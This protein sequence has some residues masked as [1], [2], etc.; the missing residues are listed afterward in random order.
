[1]NGDL[2]IFCRGGLR[3]ALDGPGGGAPVDC[4]VGR[5]AVGVG[6]CAA[7]AVHRRARG[8]VPVRG[9]GGDFG[10]LGRVVV[11]WDVADVAGSDRAGRVLVGVGDTARRV[12]A[13]HD[14]FRAGHR[15]F[16]GGRGFSGFRRAFGAAGAPPRR[17]V[18]EQEHAGRGRGAGAGFLFSVKIQ[19]AQRPTRDPVGVVGCADGIAGGF[20]GRGSGRDL[21]VLG[22]FAP[23][24]LVFGRIGRGGRWNLCRA[25]C[26]GGRDVFAAHR[27]VVGGVAASDLGRSWRRVVRIGPAH[28]VAEH[29]GGDDLRRACG[30]GAQRSVDLDV[31]AWG[32]RGASG[33]GGRLGVVAVFGGCR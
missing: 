32:G 30:D 11:G 24:G 8:F 20:S 14:R 19:P 10:A 9:D 1:M 3:A 33:R 16:G 27:P 7:R 22:V 12:A 21:G 4:S 26:G 31:R 13:D 25:V 23:S 29:S 17:A 6:R 2:G 5:R 28:V 15:R 18:L